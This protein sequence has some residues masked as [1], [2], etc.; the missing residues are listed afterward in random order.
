MGRALRPRPAATPLQPLPT[1]PSLPI[2][3]A[4]HDFPRLDHLSLPHFMRVPE[5]C[6]PGRRSD[7]V[8][9]KHHQDPALGARGHQS[10]Q[11]GA[12]GQADEGRVEVGVEVGGADGVQLQGLGGR[13]GGGGRDGWEGRVEGGRA[14]V[15]APSRAPPAARAA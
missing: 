9:V 8:H 12:R 10:V 3:P 14:G 2:L 7:M 6:N 13:E 5:V 1:P 4:G 11:L 15:S